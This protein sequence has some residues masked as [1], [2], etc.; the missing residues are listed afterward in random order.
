MPAP[1]RRMRV[2]LSGWESGHLLLANGEP[3]VPP[4]RKERRPTE[5]LSLALASGTGGLIGGILIL[6]VAA[7]IVAYDWLREEQSRAKAEFMTLKKAA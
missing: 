2:S 3:V 1:A 6:A 4:N 7:A 5:G